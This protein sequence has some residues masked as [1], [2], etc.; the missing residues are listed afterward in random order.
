MKIEN[1]TTLG[2]RKKHNTTRLWAAAAY[3]HK[4]IQ[5][6]YLTVDI[7]QVDQPQ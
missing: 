7:L 2:L 3:K 4:E 6:Y 1:S 5:L